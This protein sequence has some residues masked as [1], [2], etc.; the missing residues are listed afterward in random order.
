MTYYFNSY[1]KCGDKQF[2]NIFQAFD[3]QRATGNFPEYVVDPDL[4]Y[5]LHGIKRPKD[6]SGQYIRTLMVNRLKEI[7]KKYSKLK[8][9]YSGGT[10]SY[11]ILRLCVDND[12]YIDETVTHMISVNKNVRTNLEYYTGVQLAKQYE[13]K[14]IGKCVEIHPTVDDHRYVDQPFWFRD[15]LT[16][17]GANLP[18]RAYSLPRIAK[19]AMGDGDDVIL[20]CG[21]E[22]PKIVIED[23]Q[24]YWTIGDASSGE[25]MGIKNLIPFFHDKHNPELVVALTYATLDNNMTSYR[26]GS[27]N[28]KKQLLD[29]YGFYKTKYNWLNMSILGKDDYNENR[30]NERLIKEL[31]GH[32]VRDYMEKH[33]ETHADI[34]RLYGD[35]PYAIESRGRLVK[36]VGRYSQ[37][38]PILQDKFAG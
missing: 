33:Y 23:G 10:D 15:E 26:E 34:K 8:L 21:Y 4:I 18:R 31:A 17:P 5:A 32:G 6:L 22:K 25:M 19:H 13:G 37:K 29:S 20:L 9:L 3:E 16:C 2:H 27:Q 11:T 1:Y 30:K 35:L 12:I 38:V 36:P 28:A 24:H 14:S 7:R